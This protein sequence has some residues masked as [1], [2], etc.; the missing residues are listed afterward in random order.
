LQNTPLYWG[1]TFGRQAQTKDVMV[2]I[3]GA[4]WIET[5]LRQKS[6]GLLESQKVRQVTASQCAT[7]MDQKS[8]F[9][10]QPHAQ[11]KETSFA[12]FVNIILLQILQQMCLSG[13]EQGQNFHGNAGR[14]RKN[15]ECFRR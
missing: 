4:L 1:K 9:L 12:R 13:A 6:I 14:V 3:G 7:L 5:S 8:L 2:H 15:L 10:Q 11:K